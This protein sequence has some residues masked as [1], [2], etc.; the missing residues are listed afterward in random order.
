[1]ASSRTP[2]AP[3]APV[4]NAAAVTA[5]ARAAAKVA[6]SDAARA[7]LRTMARSAERTAGG[8]AVQQPVVNVRGQEPVS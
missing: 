4:A 8:A 5:L 6:K 2:H 3:A 7:W 1:M